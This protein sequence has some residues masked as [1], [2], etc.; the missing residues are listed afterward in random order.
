MLGQPAGQQKAKLCGGMPAIDCRS[1]FSS[2]N[3]LP[4]PF[5]ITA[6]NVSPRVEL[7]EAEK[8]T[9]PTASEFCCRRPAL[10]G[11]SPPVV[12]SWL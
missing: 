7:I 4:Y 10:S 1:F 2:L 9:E 8:V 11:G 5:G 6:A 3:Q 12:S